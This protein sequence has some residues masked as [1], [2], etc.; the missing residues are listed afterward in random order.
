MESVVKGGGA[1]PGW[2]RAVV[3]ALK[4]SGVRY[5]THVPDTPLGHL[6]ALMEPDP[7]FDVTAA[8]REEEAVG[9]AA[10]IAF[11]GGRAAAMMQT[12]GLGNALNALAS[13]AVPYQV[14][15]L[16]L[17]SQRGEAG[18]W[19]VVQVPG[20]RLVGPALDVLGIQHFTL[21]REPDVERAVRGAA[22]LAFGTRS[23]TALILS[24]LL[25]GWGP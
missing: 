8:T 1:G 11:G 7:A 19:N 2:A 12:S 10:G 25:T 3:G 4:A 13:L 18:E 24:K 23:P 20:G 15:L 5:V 6:L 22:D 17:I 9:I 16:L 21:D 14:P